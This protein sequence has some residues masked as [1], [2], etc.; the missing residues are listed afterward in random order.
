[1]YVER[2]ILAKPGLLN[3]LAELSARPGDIVTIYAE[4]ASFPGRI[5]ELLAEA[6]FTTYAD[7]IK[8]SAN[9]ESV[10]KEAEKYRTGAA[11]F[12]KGQ[13]DK[14][15]VLPPFPISRNRVLIGELDTSL[16]FE[17]LDRR[18]TIGAVLVTWGSYGIGIFDSGNLVEAKVGTGYIHKEHKKG[19]RSQKRFARRTEEQRKDFLR[20]VSNRIEE[21]FGKYTLNHIFFGGNRLIRKPLW[22]E[23]RYL[24]SPKISG[25]VLDIRYA[26]REALN[27]SLSEIMKSVV[28]TF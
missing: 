1:M 7:Q 18:Y 3:I 9:I 23:C 17:A 2:R 25:R 11:I 12:W 13:G 6:P 28:F 4:P 15:I 16:L 14:Y 10:A 26:D 24:E 20:K 19:G 5:N 22:Q 21:I 27:N 8:E